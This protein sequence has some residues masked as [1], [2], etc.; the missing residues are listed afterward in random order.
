MMYAVNLWA[1]V[2]SLMVRSGRRWWLSRPLPF[3]WFGSWQ[4]VSMWRGLDLTAIISTVL[5]FGPRVGMTEA[6]CPTLAECLVWPRLGQPII[7]TLIAG[8]FL[9]GIHPPDVAL[10]VVL[11]LLSVCQGSRRFRAC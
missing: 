10:Y 9:F 8:F 2:D 1:C 5:R 6:A 4:L 3:G 7:Y 11:T